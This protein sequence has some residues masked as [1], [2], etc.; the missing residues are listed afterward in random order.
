MTDAEWGFGRPLLPRTSMGRPRLDD[1]TMLNGIV[2][3]FRGRGAWRDV[4]EQ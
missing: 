1:R 4:P 3:K 2:G